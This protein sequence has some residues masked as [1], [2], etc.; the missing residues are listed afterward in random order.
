MDAVLD[1]PIFGLSLGEGM[2]G[3]VVRG[4]VLSTAVYT[5]VEETEI[6]VVKSGLLSTLTGLEEYGVGADARL[7]IELGKTTNSLCHS[8]QEN[9]ALDA[10]EGRS[11]SEAWIDSV[12]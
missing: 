11:R 10:G 5:E 12:C 4:P 7:S 8:R 9:N 1:A 3:L 6:A 2:T